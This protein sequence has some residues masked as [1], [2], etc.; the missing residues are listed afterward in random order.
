M[1][2]PAARPRRTVRRPT[3]RTL[4]RRLGRG[5]GV[6]A[7][8]GT[9]GR[10]RLLR[11]LFVIFLVLVGGKAV[12]L[13]S[14]PGDLARLAVQQQMHNVALPA[15]RGTIYD[16]N[17]QQLAV[18]RPL[19]TVYATPSMLTDPRAASRALASA[20]HLTGKR[21]RR[22]L[23]E[24]LSNKSQWAFVARKV[25]PQLAR[26]ALAL[27]LPG[28]GSYSEEARAYPMGG[29][30]LQ[31]LGLAGMENTGLAGLELQFDKALGGRAGV[32]RVVRDPAG[33]ALKTV[34]QTP[35]VPGANVH[36]TIDE[37]IQYTAE[38]VLAHTLR[39][40][41]AKAATA[42][43]MDPTTGAVL[44]MVNAPGVKAGK[45]GRHPAADRNRAVTDVYEP[46]SIFKLVTI[47]GALA[48]GLVKP[49]TK[50][51][52]PPTLTLYDRVIHESHA[53][54]T[55]VYTVK[56]ILKWSS[57]VG[58]VK[59]GMMMGRDRLL[60]W[61][62]A[63][64]FGKPTGIQFPGEAGGI[65]P[66]ADQWSGTSIANIPMGQGIAVTPLQMAVA[67]STVANDGIALKPRLVSRVG[68]TSY[69]ATGAHRVISATVA[70]EVRTMLAAAV[71]GGTGV[72]AQIPGYVVAGK[73]GTAE[74][75]LPNGGGYSQSDYVA[76]FIGMVP[77]AHPKLV[78]LVAV[79]TPRQSIFGGDVAAPAV[80]QIMT[81]A[82]QHLEIAP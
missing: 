40:F 56:D 59:I 54:G 50:F 74:K 67:F 6:K 44:A 30:A 18:G 15:H 10:I 42:I 80:K 37:D 47:S 52:L 55:V 4:R 66:A 53:R 12:A 11:L 39:S 78:V 28:V 41:Q 61:I 21:T 2:A 25:D 81:F 22:L 79:D 65:I 35:P 49:T 29:S 73:T 19:Q 71:A 7:G 57:N 43:V 76:S 33:Q 75:P 72:K 62:Y 3:S 34:S 24:A 1:A 77:A 58:A 13:A 31:L 16:R 82:L 27:R 68:D 26:A 48:D 14:S 69:P 51:T 8:S 70:R 63:F 20:L 60:K 9:D 23:R 32:Q 17:G 64:G 38:D 36:L 45:F 46:G 5:G